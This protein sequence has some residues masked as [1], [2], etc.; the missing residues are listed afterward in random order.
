MDLN[1]KIELIESL[2]ECEEYFIVGKQSD[3]GEY[4]YSCNEIKSALDLVHALESIA[5]GIR[6][7][8]EEQLLKTDAI[9]DLLNEFDI[10]KNE[11]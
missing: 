5:D 8:V 9:D 11:N 6:Q 3:T 7:S 1:K 2:G 4:L 10:N